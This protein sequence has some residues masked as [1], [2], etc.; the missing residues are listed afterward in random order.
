MGYTLRIG[1]LEFKY[2]NDEDEPRIEL[3]AASE[4]HENAP[5]FGEPTDYENQRWPSYTSWANFCRY[6][7]L[8]ELFYG[9]NEKGEYCRNDALIAEHPGCFPLTEKHRREINRAYESHKLKYPNAIPTYG[10]HAP[11][12]AD[13]FTKFTWEDPD[14]PPENY[15]FTRLTWLHYWVN[16]ALDNCERPVFENT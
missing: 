5:A 4:K 12:G 9:K 3:S 14:N 6:F 7:N 1:E 2:I 15:Q 11:E 16:W 10:K 13:Q 8:Y